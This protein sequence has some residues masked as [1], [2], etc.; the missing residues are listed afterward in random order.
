MVVLSL[1]HS[2]GSVLRKSFVL[3]TDNGYKGYLQNQKYQNFFVLLN[4]SFDLEKTIKSVSEE[5]GNIT[6]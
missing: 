2:L 1:F 5:R 6:S 3:C 4:G